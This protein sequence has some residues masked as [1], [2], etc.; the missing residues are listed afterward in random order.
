[1]LERG[2]VLRL[3][4]LQLGRI[5]G[6]EREQVQD[7]ESEE[8]FGLHEAELARDHRAAVAAVRAVRLVPEHAH[9]LVEQLRHAPHRPPAAIERHAVAEARDRWH[10]DRERVGGVATMR[11][12][13]GQWADHV[14]VVDERA[15]VGVQ[16]Q[17]RR[18]V[19]SF[20][21][22]WMKCTVWPSISV[23]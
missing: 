15:R 23:R 14:E 11:D 2:E 21:G 16:E 3:Q 1:M 19:A 13:V 4:L 8:A 9:Q 20:D 12:R 6:R 22:T 10:H 7:V 18:R 17:Q 5:A